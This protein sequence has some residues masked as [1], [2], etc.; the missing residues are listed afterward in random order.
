MTI[1]YHGDNY[2]VLDCHVKKGVDPWIWAY[3]VLAIT[4]ELEE[5][6]MWRTQTQ[7]L[8]AFLKD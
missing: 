5:L 8:T 7:S 2:S 6:C 1:V 4:L 3:Q